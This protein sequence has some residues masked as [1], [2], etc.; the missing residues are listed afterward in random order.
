MSKS[1]DAK[2]EFTKVRFVNRNNF[3]VKISYDGDISILD[4]GLSQLYPAG[5]VDTTQLPAGVS[6]KIV[7][8]SKG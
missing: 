8:T 5:K 4:P 6:F 7:D 1:T 2:Y 3:P